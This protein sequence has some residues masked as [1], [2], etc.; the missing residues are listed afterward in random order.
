[1]RLKSFPLVFILLLFLSSCSGDDDNDVQQDD[2]G[3]QEMP[4]QMAPFVRNFLTE[5]VDIM[6]NN[7]VNRNQ[8]DWP[9][10]RSS[11]FAIA[12][13]AQSIEEAYPALREALRRLGDNHSSFTGPDGTFLYEG[14]LI[15]SFG[16]VTQPNTPSNIGYVKVNSFSGTSNGQSAIT[17]AGGIQNQ[18]ETQDNASIIGWIVDLRGNGGG[19]MWPMIAGIGPVLGS[20][21]AGYFID[22]DGNQSEW[23]YENGRST[24]NGFTLTQLTPFYQLINSNPKVAVLYNNGI[25]SSGEAVAV[26]FRGRPNTKSFGTETCGLSTAN[27]GFELSNS[28]FLNLTIST[29]ADRNQVLYGASILPDEETTTENIIEEAIYYLTQ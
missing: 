4:V 21:T 28:S 12:S 23:G 9:V 19:N 2:D 29:F 1:M 10:F 3:Q 26:A 13:G 22:P 7:S 8:I 5:V 17:F 16:N 14:S 11:V 24:L 15:C 20:G 6:E 27:Q 18:I 25:A